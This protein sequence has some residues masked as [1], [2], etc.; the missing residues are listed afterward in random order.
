MHF[1]FGDKLALMKAKIP[2]LWF[3]LKE[4]CDIPLLAR[5]KY[6]RTLMTLVCRFLIFICILFPAP[7]H[8]DKN[9]LELMTFLSLNL[10][11]EYRELPSF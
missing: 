5:L 3:Y 11:Y 10:L 8:S 9:L 7:G 1:I 2:N 6:K 4:N